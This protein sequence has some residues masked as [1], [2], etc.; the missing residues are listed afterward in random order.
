MVGLLFE[1]KEDWDRAK[2][3]YNSIMKKDGANPVRSAVFFRICACLCVC[4]CVCVC[5]LCVCVYVCGSNHCGIHGA[6]FVVCTRCPV[7][8][9]LPWNVPVGILLLRWLH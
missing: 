3:A 9:W 4:V 2:Q 6:L 8:D 7:G 5:V 1:A